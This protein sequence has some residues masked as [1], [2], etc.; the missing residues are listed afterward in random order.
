[1][2]PLFFLL[3]RVK[4]SVRVKMETSD[5]GGIARSS[6]TP[7]ERKSPDMPEGANLTVR[8]SSPPPPASASTAA[9]S[10]NFENDPEAGPSGLQSASSNLEN[11]RRLR[12]HNSSS[13][14]DSDGESAN[15]WRPQEPYLYNRNADDSSDTRYSEQSW[16][17]DR[18][19]IPSTA[20]EP[21]S[22]VC[23]PSS[24]ST[25]KQMDEVID[26]SENES[27]QSNTQNPLQNTN[28]ENRSIEVLTAP[29]LQLDWL[30][31]SSSDNEIVCTI[32]PK[33]P[34]APLNLTQSTS[35]NPTNFSS[36]P[37]PID[38]TISDDEEIDHIREAE[39]ARSARLNRAQNLLKYS[40]FNISHRFPLR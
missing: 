39:M 35:S 1:M 20:A 17:Y 22:V 4:P 34:T 11:R 31:D 18:N 2:W 23:E 30:S 21:S 16:I 32:R 27:L 12:Y 40:M 28:N 3:Y 14:D 26:L 7:A 33:S 29:D 37:T 10:M 6:A 15:L 9:A 5:C 38:L 13:D 8:Q 25:H 24:S 19:D 36:V